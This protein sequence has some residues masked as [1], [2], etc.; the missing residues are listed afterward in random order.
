MQPCSLLQIARIWCQNV[1]PNCPLPLALQEEPSRNI[2]P[3]ALVNPQLQINNLFL[4]PP[5]GMGSTL[6]PEYQKSRFQG[7][8]PFNQQGN[9]VPISPGPC[10]N[11]G[12]LNAQA[13]QGPPFADFNIPGQLLPF[14][15]SILPKRQCPI[16][17]SVTPCT[18]QQNPGLSPMEMLSS[19]QGGKQLPEGMLPSPCST[20]MGPPFTPLIPVPNPGNDISTWPNSFPFP[21]FLDNNF[22]PLVR[23]TNP[24]LLAPS[25]D[26]LSTQEMALS[27]PL[28]QDPTPLYPSFTPLLPSNNQGYPGA[29]VDLFPVGP[30]QYPSTLNGL[31]INTLIPSPNLVPIQEPVVPASQMNCLPLGPT[32][33][34]QFDILP[35]PQLYPPAGAQCTPSISQSQQNSSPF[36][37]LKMF[38]FPRPFLF[39]SIMP[40]QDPL[41]LP[42]DP[43]RQ[44]NQGPVF[45]NQASIEQENILLQSRK[46][47]PAPEQAPIVSTIPLELPNQNVQ[48]FP[49]EFSSVFQQPALPLNL[50]LDID[51]SGLTIDEALIDL[52]PSPIIPQP[53]AIPA[54][55]FGS[56]VSY[57]VNSSPIASPAISPP[58]QID[59]LPPV[60][61]SIPGCENPCC[62]TAADTLPIPINLQINIPA[63]IVPAPQITIINAAPVPAPVS[64]SIDD[65]SY[66]DLPFPLPV[67]IEGKRSKSR[68]LLPLVLVA[69][70]ARGGDFGSYRG[71]CLCD[72]GPIP[73]PYPIPIPTNNPVIVNKY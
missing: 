47:F 73:V 72:S 55:S 46:T 1:G 32:L 34:Q 56:L 71:G 67:I 29:L 42:F 35:E 41:A 31:P 58:C 49:F 50:A 52:I 11:L 22:S 66:F 44:T 2:N 10:T 30:A 60:P 3:S 40:F 68:S 20:L 51:S 14:P 16:G 48:I 70:L 64:S 21:S 59:A 61:I 19:P 53:S 7:V 37:P 62:S 69:L 39:P 15:Q 63:P 6:I 4:H 54:N 65:S 57:S 12:P 38:K 24:G 5:N 13:L 25:I 18:S 36:S 27:P 8:L 17:P 9:V 28:P 23:I 26:V 45:A 43:V 33:S